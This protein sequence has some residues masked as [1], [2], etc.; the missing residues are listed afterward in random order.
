MKFYAGAAMEPVKNYLMDMDG[1]LV[2]GTNI[3][4]SADKF[5]ARLKQR[6]AK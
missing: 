6:G 4:P 3:V 2:T 5:L 1:V